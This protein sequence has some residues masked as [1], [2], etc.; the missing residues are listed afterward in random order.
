MKWRK[1]VTMKTSDD[2]WEELGSLAE[3]ELFHAVTKLFAFYE[4]QLLQNPE[5]QEAINFFANLDNAIAQTSQC[6]SN[7]R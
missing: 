2:I 5:N 1:A 7:R 4:K 6:N 3:D